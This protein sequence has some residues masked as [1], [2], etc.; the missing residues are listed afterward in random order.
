MTVEGVAARA[1]AAI[2]RAVKNGIGLIRTNVDIDHIGGLIAMRALAELRDRYSD[3]VDIEIVALA[4]HDLLEADSSERLLLEALDMGADVIGG[5]PRQ[6]IDDDDSRRHIDKIF[7]IAKRY[8]KRIDTHIDAACDPNLRAM[9]YLA[10]KTIREDYQGKV[11]AGHAVA[12]TYYNEYYAE[13]VIGLLNRAGIHVVTCPATTMMSA[14]TLDREPRGRGIT[15][16]RQLL[17][18]GVNVAVGQDNIDDP[19]NPFGDADPMTN[20]LLTA[21]AAQLS[22]D[23]E[24]EKLFDM[25]SRNGAR[26]L[27][28][29]KWEIALGQPATLNVVNAR[30]LREAFRERA[31]RL[32][33]IRKGRVVAT[34]EVVSQI[35]REKA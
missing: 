30:S 15:R 23:K 13:K 10:A 12:L 21:Y 20:G 3:V 7:E 9:H 14:P 35:Y 8:S 27:G 31:E 11:A 1:A 4:T 32:F 26:V 2:E 25:T 6:E 29:D 19:Y 18:A 28:K 17:A 34:T 33:V 16:V 22:T 24:L 5:S